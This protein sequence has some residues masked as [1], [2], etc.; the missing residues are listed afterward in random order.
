MTVGQKQEQFKLATLRSMAEG[1]AASDPYGDA[2][3][4]VASAEDAAMGRAGHDVASVNGVPAA[5]AAD[6]NSGV[7]AS[8]DAVQNYLTDMQGAQADYNAAASAAM[9]GYAPLPQAPS[10]VSTN[11]SLSGL[12][13]DQL[14]I[15]PQVFPEEYGGG[16]RYGGFR[17][18][19]EGAMAV[20]GLAGRYGTELT[21]QDEALARA[22]GQ[23]QAADLEHRA[24]VVAPKFGPARRPTVSRGGRNAAEEGQQARF[25]HVRNAPRGGRGLAPW[26][27]AR[28]EIAAEGRDI[29]QAMVAAMTRRPSR[30]VSSRGLRMA[31]EEVNS[32]KFNSG[33]YRF[34]KAADQQS[35]DNVV[36]EDWELQ[37]Q[38]AYDWGYNPY[39]AEGQFDPPTD[40]ERNAQI[41][42][43]LELGDRLT[44][45]DGRTLGERSVWD[46][47][48]LEQQY[49]KDV[50]SESTQ[51]QITPDEYVAISADP[52]FQ[53]AEANA[54]EIYAATNGNLDQVEDELIGYGLDRIAIR[55]I[56]AGYSGLGVNSSNIDPAYEVGG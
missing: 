35:Q 42:S 53:D 33:A 18:Q 3:K 24:S 26:Q 55:M 28:G 48:L 44:D 4:S 31:E 20:K 51:L 34:A 54:A 9:A 22:A 46:Q 15:N 29:E 39:I 19:S 5:V 23:A 37:R 56:L 52:F 1:Q 6:V 36:P 47:A 2:N 30:P 17:T 12:A 43:R 13:A 41:R 50:V 25:A 8:S 14:G 32:Q 10:Q 16:L 38:A 45:P 11:V 40:A 21:A 7:T 49:G 27:S